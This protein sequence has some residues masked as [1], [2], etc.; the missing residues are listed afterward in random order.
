[1]DIR[2]VWCS[3][4]VSVL[5]GVAIS[6]MSVA[7]AASLSSYP[8]IASERQLSADCGPVARCFPTIE[9]LKDS[10]ALIYGSGQLSI[11][12][13]SDAGEWLLEAELLDPFA[14]EPRPYYNSFFGELAAIDGDVLAV[15]AEPE[16]GPVVYIFT[17]RNGVWSYV[18]TI[19]VEH[20][21][22]SVY[23]SQLKL[24]N[25]LLLMSQLEYGISQGTEPPAAKVQVYE[26]RGRGQ[27]RLRQ[28]LAPVAEY[29]SAYRIDLDHGRVVLAAGAEEQRA[30]AVYV[31]ERRSQGR[32]PL[33]LRQIIQPTTLTVAD[34]FAAGVALDGR[35]LAVSAP[36]VAPVAPT[37]Y[38]GA[39]Y[40]YE[41][42]NDRWRYRERIVNPVT[43]PSTD[44]PYYDPTVYGD[45]MPFGTVF[46]LSGARL[47]IK[48][49]NYPSGAGDDIL[50]ERGESGWRPT[51]RIGE[52]RDGAGQLSIQATL[53]D[54][55]IALAQYTWPEGSV[56]VYAYELPEL[57]APAAATLTVEE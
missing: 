45:A 41:L 33:R 28:T 48:H 15:A 51:A 57:S 39:V 22:E 26:Q 3:A 34:Q 29:G 9:D 2:K 49:T 10:T 1:M 17:R 30:A 11:W 37:L 4:C 31:Y 19:E 50:F 25:G 56:S 35:T 44:D 47:L 27:F 42:R 23:L 20:T 13:R 5:G 8:L 16:A 18:Q 21:N 36:G 40:V 12:R 52:W 53:L 55:R 43:E 54:G 38:P 6:M 14:P 32:D 24:E 46:A 7:S